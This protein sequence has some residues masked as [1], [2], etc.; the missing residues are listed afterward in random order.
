M[1]RLEARFSHEK[2]MRKIQAVFPHSLR[3]LG[4]ARDEI[5]RDFAEA[6]P[7]IDISRIENARQ[8]YDSLCTSWRQ[9]SPDPAHLRDVAACDF[10]FA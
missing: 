6:A 7:P 3:L 8:F 10:A 9:R 1:L 5:V 4:G 2:R